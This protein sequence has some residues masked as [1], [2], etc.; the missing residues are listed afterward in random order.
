MT[1]GFTEPD[2]RVYLFLAE[3]GSHK[4]RDVAEALGIYRRRLYSILRKLQERGVVN[5]SSERPA[6]FSAV[7]FEEVLDLFM[8]AGI[9]QQEALKA[10]KEELLSNWRSLVKKDTRDQ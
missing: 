6:L 5:A 1:L 8:E 4:V 10:S 7:L 9:D 2:A 3:K